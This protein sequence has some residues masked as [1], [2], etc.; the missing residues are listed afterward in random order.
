MI[1]KLLAAACDLI[2]IGVHQSVVESGRVPRIVIADALV[3]RTW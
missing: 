3:N 2:T 1:A